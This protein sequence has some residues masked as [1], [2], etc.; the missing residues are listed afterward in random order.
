MAPMAA[1]M[2]KTTVTDVT[3][4]TPP[5]AA[6]DQPTMTDPHPPGAVAEHGADGAEAEGTD[7]EY[8]RVAVRG[9]IGGWVLGSVVFVALARLG[10]PDV[11]WSWWLGVGLG[12]AFWVGPFFGLLFA[13]A[14]FQLDL[15]A[16]RRRARPQATAHQGDRAVASAPAAPG[17][18]GLAA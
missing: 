8:G 3:V 12:T 1:L 13:N 4:T 11:S 2:T 16:A 17:A 9:L 7:A 15:E 6:A 14:A 18:V 10:L 5:S